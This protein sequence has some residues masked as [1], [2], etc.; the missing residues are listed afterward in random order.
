MS[1][2]GSLWRFNLIVS[3]PGVRPLGVRHRAGHRG[4]SEGLP[5][6]PP[7]GAFPGLTI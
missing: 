5:Y 3:V 1:R 7:R 4:A 6:F 2:K